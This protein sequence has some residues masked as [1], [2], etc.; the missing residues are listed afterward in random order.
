MY[1]RD[2]KFGILYGAVLFKHVSSDAMIEL[3]QT[4]DTCDLTGEI[5][6][7]LTDRLEQ[8]VSINYNLESLW[9]YKG[10]KVQKPKEK[11]SI[12]IK[13][14]EG[15]EFRGILRELWRKSDGKIENEVNF[16][17]SSI[18]NMDDRNQPRNIALFDEHEKRF[19]SGNSP[20]IW[21]CL[22]FKDKRVS[23]THYTLRS[24]KWDAKSIHPRSWNIEGSVDGI[25]WVEIDNR[26]DCQ[27]LNGGK[28]SHTF[29]MNRQ[30]QGQFKY[31]RVHSTGN[32][33]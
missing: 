15:R 24:Y 21:I 6:S 9:R 8:K 19:Y 26:R 29:Q 2:K 30:N 31:I 3:N 17:A 5:W 23:P 12:D 18:I 7:G 13:Y 10:K 4:F 16:T 25:N 22:D 1:I 20:G 32:D 14:R 27:F 33:W 11:H 28:L